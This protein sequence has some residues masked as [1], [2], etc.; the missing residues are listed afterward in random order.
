VYSLLTFTLDTY[1][2]EWHPEEGGKGRI[3]SVLFRVHLN[4]G[5]ATIITAIPVFFCVP[6]VREGENEKWASVAGRVSRYALEMTRCSE[7]ILF[8][9]VLSY[10]RR[11][12]SSLLR[13]VV[14]NLLSE[15][16]KWKWRLHPHGC[17]VSVLTTFSMQTVPVFVTSWRSHITTTRINPEL[18]PQH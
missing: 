3:L 18:L 7:I 11:R 9:Y 5:K 12:L 2:F 4:T 15:V 1:V 14:G 17:D 10:W 6:N 13:R 16:S 8:V